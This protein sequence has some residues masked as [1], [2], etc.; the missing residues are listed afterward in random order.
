MNKAIVAGSEWQDGCDSVRNAGHSRLPALR[1]SAS[2]TLK[3]GMG[4]TD[5]ADDTDKQG[6][7]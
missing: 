7:V 5:E 3:T 1:P 2:L 4:T 6:F